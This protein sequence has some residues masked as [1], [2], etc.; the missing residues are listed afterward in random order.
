MSVL[1]ILV[2]GSLRAEK[3]RDDDPSGVRLDAERAVL[4]RSRH[5]NVVSVVPS[6]SPGDL[7]DPHDDG[8][9]ADPAGSVGMDTGSGPP[10][11]LLEH[12]G[13]RTWDSTPPSNAA[14]LASG[15]A[16]IAATVADLHD[17]GVAH[18]Q[19]TDPSHVI[20]ADN[21]RLVLCGFG[22]AQHHDG[23]ADGT[24]SAARRRDVAALGE[25]TYRILARI[26]EAPGRPDRSRRH[27][28]ERL[29]EEL[30][31]V[32]G[33]ASGSRGDGTVSLLPRLV[34]ARDV[35]RKAAV[36]AGPAVS[37]RPGS[38]DGRDIGRP[39]HQTPDLRAWWT[40][41]ASNWP[42]RRTAAMVGAATLLV[43]AAILA[44]RPAGSG[45]VELATSSPTA[46]A[47]QTTVPA[48]APP[49][50][51]SATSATPAT[52][53]TTTS[54]APPA[55]SATSTSAAPPA[56]PTSGAPPTGITVVDAGGATYEIVVGG[57]AIASVAD[58][59]CDG[60]PTAAV[61]RL[62]TGDVWVFDQ[63]TSDDGPPSA[64]HVDVVPGASDLG[65][66]TATCPALVATTPVGDH[67][68]DLDTTGAPA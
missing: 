31:G 39:T 61:L 24:C 21:G 26:D 16:S 53:A 41:L 27:A 29:A 34:T 7:E 8:D 11:L 35:A 38:P 25:L 28:L 43:G 54:T 6:G 46:A 59:N 67:V 2:D 9:R 30:R 12:A 58:W 19:L 23:P 63:W 10:A 5:P 56:T 64:R 55:T 50:T 17:L 40:L 60:V 1:H 68:V 62:D 52:S 49:A 20:V 4:A 37:G 13:D 47:P 65:P 44:A 36:I 45:S 22:E 66:A 14:D 57:P 18:G 32:S 42:G 48:T 51:T 3:R 33:D 15:L